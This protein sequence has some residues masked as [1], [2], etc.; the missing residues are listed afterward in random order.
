MGDTHFSGTVYSKGI[1]TPGMGLVGVGKTFFVHGQWTSTRTSGDCQEASD[2]NPGTKERPFKTLTY[3]LSQCV[4]HRND[5]IYVLDFY[6][7]STE[8]WPITISKHQV[9]IIGCQSVLGGPDGGRIPWSLVYATGNKAAFDITGNQ[10]LL[11][12][13][14]IYAGTS[15]YACITMDS[16]AAVITVDNC[17]FA[18]G[19]YGVH[20]TTADTQYGINITNCTFMNALSAGGILIDDD[21][22]F[23]VISGNYFD[24]HTGVSIDIRNGTAHRIVNNYIAMGANTNG[25]A[26]KLG[27]A[28][29]RAWVNNNYAAYGIEDGTTYPYTDNGTVNDNNW[30][31]NFFGMNAVEPN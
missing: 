28:V 12:G 2:S 29:D 22:A 27:D 20:L 8:T 15:S 3:A 16:D 6:Q 9:S 24:R 1:P 30:G 18:R 5:L 4:D 21:P 25:T 11:S 19:T 17:R 23:C 10:V 26:I 13:F 31:R 7:P 14:Q